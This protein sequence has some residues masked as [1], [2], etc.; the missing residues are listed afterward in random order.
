MKLFKRIVTILCL[1]ACVTSLTV[2]SAT[3]ASADLSWTTMEAL[4]GRTP[5]CALILEEAKIKNMTDW[6]YYNVDGVDVWYFNGNGMATGNPEIRFVTEETQTQTKPYTLV[7]MQVDSFSFNYRIDNAGEKGVV[8]LESVN[9]IV[10]IL[11][12]DGSYPIITPEIKTDGGWHTITVDQ[13]T[14]VSNTTSGVSTYAGIDDMFCGFLFKMGGLN[15]E[16]MISDIDIVSNGFHVQPLNPYEPEEPATSEEPE[17]SETPDISEVPEEPTTS[18]TPDI[19]EAPEEPTTSETPDISEVPE[20]PATSENPQDQ[21]SS[22]SEISFTINGL[23]GC[24]SAMSGLST[25]FA[26]AGAGF[27]MAIRKKKQ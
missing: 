16:F 11:C 17:T 15:G 23:I 18:E 1:G 21:T 3:K 24:S 8:D 26:L 5:E 20:Q 2:S 22:T 25:L 6:G 13:F 19:S 27:V 4:D 7:P 10:Q 12:S 14:S 9:Y